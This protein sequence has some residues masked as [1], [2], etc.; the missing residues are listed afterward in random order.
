[1]KKLLLAIALLLPVAAYADRVKAD[2]AQEIAEKFL[3]PS[4]TKAGGKTL[5]LVWRGEKPGEAV[6][7]EPA[8]YVYNAAG[9]GFVVVSGEDV[10]NPILAYSDTQS[11]PSADNIAPGLADWMEGLQTVIAQARREGLKPTAAVREAW[12]AAASGPARDDDDEIFIETALWD[13]GAPYNRFCPEVDGKQSIV[14]CVATAISILMYHYKHPAKGTGVLP[15]Y[16]Y[17]T[18]KGN[19]RKQD[20]KKLGD[21]YDWDNM[22]PDYR[23]S[24]TD[25]QADAVAELM[26]DVAVMSQMQFNADGSGA[27]TVFAAKQLPV[28]MGYD[29]SLYSLTKSYIPVDDWIGMIAAEI[30][31]GRLVLY[32]GYDS[33][34][35]HAFICDGYRKSDGFLRFNWGWSGSG[36]GF[37]AIT[38]IGGFTRGNY[39]VFHIIPDEGG[40]APTGTVGY[41]NIKTNQKNITKNKEF[42]VT[43]TDIIPQ[44]GSFDRIYFG[45]GKFTA[46]GE[47]QEIPSPLLEAN[48]E[49]GRYYPSVDFPT[50]I[51]TDILPGDYLRPV[52]TY[53]DVSDDQPDEWFLPLFNQDGGGK[54]TLVLMS[55]DALLESTHLRF[56]SAS[57]VI[58]VT[59]LAQASVTLKDAKGKDRS[60]AVK[61]SDGTFT[62]D[63]NALEKGTYTFS[64]SLNGLSKT[65]DVT[66]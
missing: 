5:S 17:T 56:D 23:G 10:L 8:F 24:Y 62:V 46:A 35:G 41:T 39:A 36:N 42:N 6:S 28:Y 52:A 16:N 51:E 45:L 2:K 59:T 60:S 34:G 4:G 29:K 20:G 22:L 1:M 19:S 64:V 26:F 30:D 47:F 53:G 12:T 7:A 18:N 49:E 21:E 15:T 11:F 61:G 33:E 54:E 66:L 43:V 3:N 50:L 13:Q 40:E 63:G 65:F 37:Y 55:E 57:R 58:T 25:A 27:V 48:L 9:G 38:D 14:G 31:E 44:G 32:S